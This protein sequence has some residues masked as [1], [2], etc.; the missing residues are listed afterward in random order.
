MT[1]ATIR[2]LLA[3]L[4]GA[5]AARAERASDAQLLTRFRTGRDG[6]AFA[7]LVRRHGGLVWCACRRVLGVGPDAEDAFQA[8]FLVLLRKAGTIRDRQSLPAWLYAV[9]HRVAVQALREAERRRRRE[10]RSDV[11]PPA[12]PVDLSW[13]EAVAVLHEELDRLPE[14]FR[15]PLL[16]CVVEGK[17]RDEAA[18]LLGWT[19][20]AVKGRLE[21]G[22]EALRRRLERRGIALSVGLLAASAAP[23]ASAAVPAGLTAAAARLAV[24]AAPVVGA[25][26]ARLAR[27]ASP[28]LTGLSRRAVVVGVLALGLLAV[29]V[30][31]PA[32]KPA[33]EQPA[34]TPAP[35]IEQP[36]GPIVTV[37]GQVVDAAGKPVA[38][39]KLFLCQGRDSAP[40]PAPQPAADADGRFR[41]TLGPPPVG[42]SQRSLLAAAPGHG[43]DWAEV[44]KV[45]YGELTLRL[46]EDVPIAGLVLDLE[47]QPVAGAAVRVAEVTTTSN[48]SLADFLSAWQTE[49][50][51]P[52]QPFRLLRRRVILG[53]AP[54]P[55]PA[56]TTDASGRFTLRGVGRDR[57][58]ILHVRGRGVADQLAY[59]ALRPG[60]APTPPTDGRY[61]LFGPEP[62]IALGPSKPVEGVVCDAK[63]G[64]PLAGVHVVAHLD[65]FVF[66]FPVEVTTDAQG[67]YRFDGLVK[68]PKRELTLRPALGEPYLARKLELT[69]TAGLAPITADA[70]LTRGVLVSGR[71]FDRVTGRPARGYVHYR[72]LVTNPTART[73]PDYEGIEG[74]LTD[75]AGRYRLP[76]LPGPGVLLVQ[77]HDGTSHGPF[78]TARVTAADTDPTIFDAGFNVFRVQGGGGM[79]PLDLLN[80]YRRIDPP[81]GASELSCDIPLE[82][83]L[84]RA[85][86]VLD[87]DGRPLVGAIGYNLS[88][89]GDSPESLRDATFTVDGLDPDRPRP[90]LVVHRDR[91]LAGSLTLRGDE[92][93]PVTV[94]L[95]PCAAVTGRVVTDDG[96][97]VAGV[98]A[99]YSFPGHAFITRNTALAFWEPPIHTDA[100]GRF[101]LDGIPPG[102]QVRIGLERGRRSVQ[103]PDSLNKLTLKPGEV[104]EL[105]EFKVKRD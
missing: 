19:A 98:R 90:I 68:R 80:A 35:A 67:R 8:T 96:Q 27:G 95:Q 13:R 33:A 45:L 94:R 88:S 72:A 62:V 24:S 81:V 86:R 85:C 79:Y 57:V 97:P 6:A 87:P 100:A 2:P 1:T 32:D 75:E 3:Q 50:G 77:T 23:G 60:F 18:A 56:V 89:V 14:A 30:A 28:G 63:T 61:H 52:A 53:P 7:A 44:G 83:G 9:A 17:T 102:V 36:A 76:A 84:K 39:A 64:R 41:F 105:G 73:V 29:S 42:Y 65:S 92:P 103:V 48:D 26:V 59:V 46:P 93:E 55:L 47:G 58:A 70:E 66:W 74:A 49:K 78:K 104:K 31:A 5:A 25:G 21:R 11:R 10:L 101:R 91:N 4:G 40:T 99:E 15:R 82:P 71:L 38:G 51:E 54:A 37:A 43:C 16:L 22:R 34:K 69:D 20:G 12:E